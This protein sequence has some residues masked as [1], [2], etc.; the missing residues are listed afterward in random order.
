V[1]HL[2]NIESYVKGINNILIEIKSLLRNLIIIISLSAV[3]YLCVNRQYE[4]PLVPMI[5][6]LIY[7]PIRNK[8]GAT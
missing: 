8:S 3:L 5:K 6:D 7:K 1:K 4:Y 2:K